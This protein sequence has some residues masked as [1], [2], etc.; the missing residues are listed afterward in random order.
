MTLNWLR[1]NRA[2]IIAVNQE[3][4]VRLAVFIAMLL[5]MLSWE[6]SRPRRHCTALSW[7]RRLNNL[8]LL[9]LDTFVVR[10]LLPFSSVSTALLAAENNWGIFNRPGVHVWLAGV[11]SFLLLD[12]VIYLQHR[13][14][15]KYPILWRLHRVHHCDTEFDTTTGL[16]FHPLEILISLLVKVAAVI[17]I[18]PPVLAVIV[19]EI[20]LNATSLFNHGNVSIAP[21]LDRCLRCLLVTPDMHRVH[22]SAIK[23]E[24]DSNFGFNITWWDWLFRSYRA[25]PQLG[26]DNMRIGLNEFRDRRFVN[27]LW[28]LKQPLLDSAEF[29]DNDNDIAINLVPGEEKDDE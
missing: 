18:G 24:T 13:I 3:I 15:H 28:L 29:A 8:L 17:V 22:H 23:Q 10:L 20:I 11:M 7:Q 1:G 26:H 12:L 19:F 16:R 27:V 25:Q 6:R 21:W 5:L 4:V 2:V 14:F 9:A